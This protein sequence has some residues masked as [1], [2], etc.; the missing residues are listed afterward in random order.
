MD[1]A[2]RFVGQF[3]HHTGIVFQG[4]M[5]GHITPHLDEILLVG[6][7]HPYLLGAHAWRAHHYIH[8]LAH[9]ILRH[10]HKHLVE[11]FLEAFEAESRNVALALMGHTGRV[12]P[13]GVQ[14]Q[15]H[16]IHLPSG[17]DDFVYQPFV[18]GQTSLHVVVVPF[19]APLVKPR[20]VGLCK[21]VQVDDVARGVFKVTPVHM[22]TGRSSTLPRHHQRGGEHQEQ[23]NKHSFH[24]HCWL[25]ELQRYY[26]QATFPLPCVSY[27]L[28]RVAKYRPAVGAGR[29]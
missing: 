3:K 10:G 27:T 28:R 16:E 17:G 9:D 15:A 12:A 20:T 2:H 23:R 6:I 13:I 1:N 21:S 7:A 4:G 18:V 25:I 5:P 11:I 26:N 19:R 29:W 14:M 24:S 22:Q 8:A